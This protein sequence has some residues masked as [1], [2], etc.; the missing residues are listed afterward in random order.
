MAKMNIKKGDRVKVITGKDAGK[1]STVVRGIP[2][3]N[4]VVVEGV[5]TGKKA[6]RPTRDNQ[7]GGIGEFDAP[8]DASNV[9]LVCPACDTP[10]R[11]AHKRVDGK[12]V[13]VCKR[14]G[15]DID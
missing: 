15:A 12:V 4:R 13:R 2:E 1:V 6:Q 14:C 11:V 9:M 5:A 7:K 8:I 10:T 3:K